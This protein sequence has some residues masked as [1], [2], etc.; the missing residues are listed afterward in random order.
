[1]CEECNAVTDGQ[2]CHVCGAFVADNAPDFLWTDPRD[3][4]WF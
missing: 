1:M 4:C 2:T 3:D